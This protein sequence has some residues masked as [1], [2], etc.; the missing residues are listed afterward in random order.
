M[1]EPIRLPLPVRLAQ[2]IEFPH[3]L[4]ICERLFSKTLTRNRV[5]WVKTA[6]G[7]LWKL[8]LA[9]STH[10]WIIYGYYEGPGIFQ[11][12]RRNLRRNAVFVDSGANIG[13][14]LLYFGTLFPNGRICAFEP[15][16]YQANWLEECLSSNPQLPVKLFR[17]GLGD[18]VRTLYLSKVG[19]KHSHG[20]QNIVTTDPI[21][22][23]VEVVPLSQ[24]LDEQKFDFV[25]LWKLDVEGSELAALS[26]AKEWL[27]QKKIRALW[28][29]TMGEN[30][31][32]IA[33]FMHGIG[34]RALSLSRKGYESR[35]A[36][37]RAN[38]TLFI[39]S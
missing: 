32:R 3:K 30:G 8:D 16:E 35:S 14:T 17:K 2:Q 6:I 25:D 31:R 29:E 20:G 39:A 33:D 21:G 34:Y 1:I 28:I 27:Q 19:H 18:T 15:G 9:N 22:E 5:C 7:P 24:I 38:N 37:E 4:G 10:R 23:P 11:W 12:S 36:D 26:G 13:Q